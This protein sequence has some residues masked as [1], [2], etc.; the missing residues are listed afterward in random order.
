MKKK[1]AFIGLGDVG[2][3]YSSG[4][5]DNGAD[6]KGFDLR[7]GQPVFK[8][9]EERITEHGV[10]MAKDQRD[11]IEGSDIILV[12]TSCAETVNCAKMYAPYLKAGQIYVD[13]NSSVPPVKKAA[14][15]IIEATGA[16]FV[17]AVTMQSPLQYWHKNPCFMS[18]KRAKEVVD[19]LNGFDMRLGYVGDQVGQ[20]SALK[21]LRSIFTKG[22][23]AILI[24]CLA[25]AK[26]YG[27][28]DEVFASICDMM[29]GTPSVDQLAMMVRTDVLH[30]K[31]RGEEI[32]AISDMLKEA[33]M[34]NIMSEASTKKLAWSAESDIK[35]Y[36]DNKTPEDLKDCVDAF[37]R[38]SRGEK[39]TK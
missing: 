24:E 1:I 10:A 25:S 7:F 3:R 5:S 20:A 11:V 30:A 27:V 22:L 38:L 6:V 37:M 28:M 15:A 13:Y 31:R 35:A 32:G 2:S 39:L 18:G 21:V 16:D 8:E 26:A 17:D 33:G 14:Q 23:E 4:I 34:S 9:Y 36:F 19:Y 12:P 29:D